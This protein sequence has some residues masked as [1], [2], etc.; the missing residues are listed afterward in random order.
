MKMEMDKYHSKN[1]KP[2]CN[3]WQ[4]KKHYQKR[5]IRGKNQMLFH[6]K[7]KNEGFVFNYVSKL[8]INLLFAL[9]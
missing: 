1:F 9:F 5:K 8:L 6:K 7:L 2:L 4:M 3:H